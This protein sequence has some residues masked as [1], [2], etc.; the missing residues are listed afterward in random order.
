MSKSL[1]AQRKPFYLKP[2]MELIG[3]LNKI[4]RDE[5]YL[6][7]EIADKVLAFRKESDEALYIQEKLNIGYIGREIA[8]LRTDMPEKPILIH[9]GKGVL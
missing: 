7:L 5:H 6:Y 1:L 3:N 8:L 4:S 9:V 2:W